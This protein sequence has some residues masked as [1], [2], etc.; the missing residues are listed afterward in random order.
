VGPILIGNLLLFVISLVIMAVLLPLLTLVTLAVGPGLYLVA[1]L[2]RRRLFPASWDAQQQ[3]GA[4]AGV[5]D[6][7]IAGVRVVKGFGQESQELSK[8]ES[9]ARRLFASRMRVTRLTSRYDPALQAIPALG[10]V[11]VLAL[12]GWWWAAATCAA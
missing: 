12:G 4:L 7:A 11:G 10:Q 6:D 1:Q 8:L 9:A 3:T 2:S 5:V